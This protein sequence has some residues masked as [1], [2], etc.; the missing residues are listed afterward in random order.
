MKNT[1]TPQTEQIHTM[2]IPYSIA[3]HEPSGFVL[4]DGEWEDDLDADVEY[5][6]AMTNYADYA[7]IIDEDN[8]EYVSDDCEQEHEDDYR[9]IEREYKCEYT[10]E[11]VDTYNEEKANFEEGRDS[12]YGYAMNDGGGRKEFNSMCG[13]GSYFSF[14]EWLIKK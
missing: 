2:T 3:V 14:A 8:V 5:V 1:I 6:G 12:F 10:S 4:V 13:D 11:D 7:D 9:I